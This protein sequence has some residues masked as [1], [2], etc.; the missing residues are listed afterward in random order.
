M[1]P[2]LSAWQI[3][4]LAGCCGWLDAIIVCLF[5]GWL[6]GHMVG[7]LGGWL[8][9]W[10]G[11]FLDGWMVPVSTCM[12]VCLVWYGQYGMAWYAYVAFSV[13]VLPLPVRLNLWLRMSMYL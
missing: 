13:C 1:N 11:G 4:W 2:W 3:A 10:W 6:P 8:V 12:Y 5:V 9:G 7:W